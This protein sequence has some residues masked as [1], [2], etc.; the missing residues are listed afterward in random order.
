MPIVQLKS[1]YETWRGKSG[2][3]VAYPIAGRMFARE[4][5]NP[6][7]PDDANQ[8][9]V[10]SN[11]ATV[12][13]AF[14]SLTP[15]EKSAWANL[16]AQMNRTDAN[17]DSYTLSA[18]QAYVSVNTLRLLDGQAGTDTA[19]SFTTALAPT[20]DDVEITAPNIAIGLSNTVSGILYYARISA[21]LPGETRNAYLR[22][23][24]SFSAAPN[25]DDSI[26]DASGTTHSL[27]IP[28]SQ[29]PFS[30]SGGD[31]IGVQVT[32]ISAD[33]VPGQKA[34]TQSITVTAI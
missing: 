8:Q 31:R 32:A 22:D 17:G 5:V 27:Q 2:D 15:A 10:R 18:V 33:Y 3:T 29:L 14:Q 16:G 13:V 26:Q 6:S 30:L 4:F 11:L 25:Q 19:P 21:P 9:S 1:P 34:F 7:N 20:I 28:T 23:L 24:T 12:A